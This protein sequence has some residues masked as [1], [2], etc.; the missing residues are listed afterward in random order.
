MMS[1]CGSRFR[2][3]TVRCYWS[4]IAHGEAR[5]ASSTPHSTAARSTRRWPP[6][7][8]DVDWPNGWEGG[9][10]A[11]APPSATTGCASGRRSTAA[12]THSM[13]TA[14]EDGRWTVSDR[15]GRPLAPGRRAAADEHLR[16]VY[17]FRDELVERMD[18]EAVPLFSSARARRAAARTRRSPQHGRGGHPMAGEAPGGTMTWPGSCH[19]PI[20][21]LQCPTPSSSASTPNARIERR[22]SSPRVSPTSPERRLSRS[23]R[24]STIPSAT[25]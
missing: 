22:S 15:P 14:R 17:T 10:I 13:I 1:L 3:A 24:T 18:I 20:W 12:S 16:H 6:W 7:T 21:S 11:G 19:L 4:L 9:R 23:R 8:D 25:R 2:R 5:P